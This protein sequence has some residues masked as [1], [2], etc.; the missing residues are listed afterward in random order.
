MLVVALLGFADA[1]Y[2]TAE[3]YL[4]VAPP[5]SVTHG[6]EKVL[7]S[8]YATIANVPIALGGAAFY[9]VVALL[10][11]WLLMQGTRKSVPLLFGLTVVGLLTSGVLVYLQLFV[12]H[13]I[14][15]YCMGSAL[16]STLLFVFGLLLFQKQKSQPNIA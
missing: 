7:T 2:L 10:S 5:C 1:T 13:S 8:Q 15:L 16:S 3:H 11:L 4:N 12:L 14:C 9:F 6:C